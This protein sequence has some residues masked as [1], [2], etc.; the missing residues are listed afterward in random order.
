MLGRVVADALQRELAAPPPSSDPAAVL[1]RALRLAADACALHAAMPALDDLTA[2]RARCAADEMPRIS[3]RTARRAESAA[4]STAPC[5]SALWHSRLPWIASASGMAGGAGK[6]GALL[7][8]AARRHAH[9]LSSLSP[10]ECVWLQRRGGEGSHR[11]ALPKAGGAAEGACAAHP[12][13]NGCASRLKQK[14]F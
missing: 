10:C 8:C 4:C 1:A 6:Q 12:L 14:Q 3:D 11:A 13:R 7:C 2:L 5:P 9:E